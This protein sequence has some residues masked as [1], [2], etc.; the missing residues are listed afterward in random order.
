MD[1]LMTKYYEQLIKVHTS[2]E[3]DCE[4]GRNLLFSTK[5]LVTNRTVPKGTLGLILTFDP[6]YLNLN[7]RHQLFCTEL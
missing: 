1:Q 3:L 6:N 7:L 4:P 2:V 5:V